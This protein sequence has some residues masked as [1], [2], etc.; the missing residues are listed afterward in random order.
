MGLR[1]FLKIR[2]AG[3]LAALAAALALPGVI[4]AGGP[5]VLNWSPSTNGGFDFGPVA[6]GQSL[7]QTFTLTNSG[8]SASAALTI[9]LSGSTA[10]AIAVDSCTGRSLGP[11]KSCGVDV[12]YAPTSATTNDTATLTAKGVKPAAV[13]ALLLTGRTP[14]PRHLYW[15]NPVPGPI[16]TIGRA[17]VTGLNLNNNFIPGVDAPE[18][19]EVDSA[20]VYWASFGAENGPTGTIG[21]ADLDGNNVSPNFIVAASNINGI[22]VDAGHIYWGNE[23]GPTKSIGR[24]DLNG[25]NVNQ[26]FIS[27]SGFPFAVTVD[28]SHVYWGNTVTNAIGRADLNGQNV[29]PNFITGVFQPTDIA[30][31]STHIYWASGG[32]IGRSDLNGQNINQNF[33]TGITGLE[34]VTVDSGHLY[35][36]TDTTIARSDL[37]GQN[38]N[39]NFITG[40][41]FPK[42]VAVD[43][44]YDWKAIE[45]RTIRRRKMPVSVGTFNL[46][47]LFSRFN[48]EADVSTAKKSTVETKT[49]FT[50]S[51]PTGFKLRT[52]K[53]RLV[54]EKPEAERKLIASRI[55]E[56][57]L[58]V[59]AVQEVE[60]I[61]TLR[62]FVRE[63]LGGLYN[64][65]V[66]IER[67]DPRLIDVGLLSKR[68]FGGVTSWQAVGDP[69]NAVG[70]RGK[71]DRPEG[72]TKEA[73]LNS[74]ISGTSRPGG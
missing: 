3:A 19:V 10:F 16:G 2:L 4:Q 8:G 65:S 54:K 49:T 71:P 42:G 73:A 9:S 37:N 45:P 39:P 23:V 47:N 70:S 67:N 27:V 40:L 50:F 38:V 43:L 20:H 57:D 66:L 14:P 15:G 74:H 64:H 34:G 22:A 31:D 48:F 56:M 69:P 63:D 46:N 61:N 41:A 6:V 21:R 28:S 18:D 29:D 68:P 51:D 13:A 1:G 25:Q 60:D 17:D 52:Y 59:L 33:I 44:G 30:V 12:E 24:A 58:D 53:G 72:T 36:T 7:S 62:R 26:N 5:P 35:W 11:R 55:K 32:R